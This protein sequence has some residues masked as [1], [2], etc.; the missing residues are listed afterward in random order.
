MSRGFK[1]SF[2]CIIVGLPYSTSTVYYVCFTPFEEKF[3]AISVV[4]ANP[5]VSDSENSRIA[6][7]VLRGS[8]QNLMDDI[9]RA[10]DDGVNTFKAL[11][12][13]SYFLRTSYSCSVSRIIQ[14]YCKVIFVSLRQLNNQ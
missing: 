11:T 14:V 12:R 1:E 13:V 4:S 10:I 9:E 2:A 3:I 8:T 6:T 7:I 5:T